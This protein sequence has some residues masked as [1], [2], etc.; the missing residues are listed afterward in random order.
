MFL[1]FIVMLLN[2]LF[3]R[4]KYSFIWE[5]EFLNSLNVI[6]FVWWISLGL[7]MMLVGIVDCLIYVV[8]M[9]WV[10][11]VCLCFFG[12]MVRGWLRKKILLGLM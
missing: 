8:R 7:L 2:F 1:L 6:L 11:V 12:K 9:M 4:V 10:K 3:R 5:C